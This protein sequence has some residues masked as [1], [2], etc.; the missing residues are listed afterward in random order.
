[1]NSK[2]MCIISI[3]AIIILI[4]SMGYADAASNSFNITVNPQE[5]TARKGE[6]VTINLGISDIDQSTDGIHAIQGKLTF[7]ETLFESVDIV[8]SGSNWS[9][10]FN[11][12]EGNAKK[13]NFVLTNLNSVKDAGVVAQ[14]RAKIKSNATVDTGSIV[15]QDVYSSYGIEETQ[16]VSKTITVNILPEEEDKEPTQQEPSTQNPPSGSTQTP[17]TQNTQKPST[18]T[19]KPTTRLPKAGLSSWICIAIIVGAIGAIVGYIRY[20]KTY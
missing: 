5:A 17:S 15:L 4:V 10:Q 8:S 3:M 7:D 1:M 11:Q 9:T 18:T 19:Q 14:I 16:K 20:K 12:E 13:G 2:K 6:T